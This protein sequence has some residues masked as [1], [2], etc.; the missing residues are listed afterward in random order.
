MV[1]KKGK[2]EGIV[3][4]CFHITER[5]KAEHALKK[6]EDKFAKIFSS[7][8]NPICITAL[9]GGNFID[10]NES[11]LH[12]TG[13]SREEIIGHNA[14]DLNLWVGD[15]NPIKL[16][17]TLFEAGSL[18]NYEINSRRKSGELRTGLFSGNLIE[19]DGKLCMAL[20]ITD[21]TEQKL[22]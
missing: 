5:K 4:S 17:K 21:I 16:R 18:C 15:D 10:V 11:F 2:V 20:V 19:I 7:S 3:V 9:D 22:A 8:P 12:F 13:Y 1:K 6:S 14:A